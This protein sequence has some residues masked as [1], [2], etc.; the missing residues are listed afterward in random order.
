MSRSKD[1]FSEI[2][3]LEAEHREAALIELCG[4]DPEL[5]TEVRALLGAFQENGG[6]L[7]APLFSERG[8]LRPGDRL[9][10]YVI[11]A[12]VGHGGVGEV[13]RARGAQSPGQVV[14]IK[15]LAREDLGEAEQ[16]RF[17]RESQVL[18][19]CRHPNLVEVLETGEDTEHGILYHLMRFVEGPNLAAVLDR[20]SRSGYRP[21][22]EDRRQI[23]RALV[24]VGEALRQLH[25]AGLVHGDVKPANIVLE[26]ASLERPWQSGSRAILLDMGLVRAQG[27]VQSTIRATPSYASP[28]Q[29]EG[30]P[31]DGRTDVYSLGVTAHD[32]ISGRTPDRRTGQLRGKPRELEPLESLVPEVDEGLAR[33]VLVATEPSKRARYASMKPLLADLKAW[34]TGGRI[35]ARRFAL[36]RDLRRWMRQHPG[37][38]VRVGA[39]TAVS[40]VV[41]GILIG[42]FTDTVARANS[43]ESNWEEGDLEGFRE[44]IEAATFLPLGWLLDPEIEARREAIRQSDINDVVVQILAVLDS[45]GEVAAFRRAAALLERDGI[46]AH[47]EL[48]RFLG[49]QWQNGKE[50]PSKTALIARLFFERPNESE[51]ENRLSRSLQDQIWE[52]LNRSRTVREGHEALTILSGWGELE[53]LFLLNEWISGFFEGGEDSIE[54]G[55]SLLEPTQRAQT[56]ILRRA[57]SLGRHRTWPKEILRSYLQDVLTLYLDCESKSGRKLDL[58]EGFGP[59]YRGAAV[60]ARDRFPDVVRDALPDWELH[61]LAFTLATLKDD[62]LRLVL[63]ERPTHHPGLLRHP[64][65]EIADRIAG[66]LHRYG[67]QVA[68]YEDSLLLDAARLIAKEFGQNGAI[69]PE[70]AQELFEEGVLEGERWLEASFRPHAPD[71][72]THLGDELTITRT[73]P[74]VATEVLEWPIPT[75]TPAFELGWDFTRPPARLKGQCRAWYENVLTLDD[76]PSASATSHLRL[77]N[78]GVSQIGLILPSLNDTLCMHIDAQ[79]SRRWPLFESGIANLEV[80]QNDRH[81]GTTRV[82]QRGE[83]NLK[84][85]PDGKP[86]EWEFRIRLSRDSTT[87]AR[88]HRV[89][90]HFV[91]PGYHQ[92]CQPWPDEETR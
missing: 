83:Y 7:D 4:S 25:E 69:P 1:A 71:P 6:L 35:V 50:R 26:G 92:P 49:F 17:L 56:E 57:R 20:W 91:K 22:R 72:G 15:I 55:L 81:I 39:I 10:P 42:G 66:V 74:E 16:R 54:R 76:K 27:K 29:W 88:V 9:G 53:D 33:I 31:L 43:V 80:F 86:Q 59:L 28:E 70:R 32:L 38:A 89:W 30:E 60:Y 77:L 3:A 52:I 19:R 18:G 41:T 40:L 21:N 62:E 47:P 64:G 82:F 67:Q 73:D 87:T 65:P 14:A 11:E 58:Y 46:P 13:Y 75:E 84:V 34:E 48:L 78:P 5:L 45:D 79:Q 8:R 61:E 36:L 90:M 68:A 51:V 44:Q 2:I 37:K 24:E 63:S 12:L 85:F 23:V